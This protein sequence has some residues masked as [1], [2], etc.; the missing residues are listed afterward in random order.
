MNIEPHAE[1]AVTLSSV[2]LSGKAYDPILRDEYRWGVWTMPQTATGEIDH[3]AALTGDDLIEFVNGDLFPYLSKFKVS[4]ESSDTIE[5]KIGE[6]FSEIKNKLQSEYSL[7]EVLNLVDELKFQ[8]SKDKHAMS[9]LYE[10]K[11]KNM[12]NGGEYP[13][14][15]CRSAYRCWIIPS[16]RLNFIG[17]RVCLS[18]SG[19]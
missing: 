4:A 12:G 14:E 9:H 13:A 8:T 17:F 10:A 6:A 19:K 18:P 5:Y 16:Y 7:R 1:V 2:S 3:H 15:Y 11:I